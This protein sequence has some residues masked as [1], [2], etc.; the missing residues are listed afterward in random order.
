MRINYFNKEIFPNVFD[1][2]QYAL[3][4]ISGK[5][6]AAKYV[7]GSC[8]RFVNDLKRIEED[9][10]CPFYF[11][12][13][14]AERYLKLTQKFTHVVGHWDTENILY[15]PWQ[16]FCFA[17]IMGFYSHK[18]NERRFR[19]AHVEV[20]R[21]NGKSAMA[22]MA[23]LYFLALD[24]SKGNHISCVATRRDQARL[25]L[26]SARAMAKANEKFLKATG[27][28]VL[29]HKIIQE[30]TN[31]HVVAVSSDHSGLDGRADILAI[32]DELHQMQ[33]KTFE[34]IESGMAKRTDSL[35]LAITTSGYSLDGIGYS[36]SV[37]AK[38]V[39]TG[40]VIDESFFSIV[41][42]LDEG[43]DIFDEKNW[44]KA[45]PNLGVSVDLEK[46]RSVAFKAKESPRDIPNFKI[47]NLNLWL[48]ESKA[49]FDL[50][51]WDK[52]A[53]TSLK[54]E[55]FYGHKCFVG[56][57]LASKIDLSSF[58]YVFRK[59]GVYYIFDKTF[60]PED[61]VTHSRNA[62]YDNCI[63]QGHLIATPGEAIHYPKIK[64]DF[65]QTSKNVKIANALYDPWNATSFAQDCQNERIEMVEFRM[66][67]ANLSEP[68]KNLD[69]LIRQGKIRHNGSPL[70]RW[71]LGNVTAKEDAAGNVFP[72]KN[73][74][75]LKIDPIIALIMAVAAWM[76]EK[77][78][79]SNYATRGIR[80][81]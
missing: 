49:F 38:K 13:E 4:V 18:T 11:I 35:L 71:C 60:I 56:I 41:Y 23:C 46:L 67:T 53:D 30:S 61:T 24:K 26:D 44:F 16:K 47:K 62:L 14:K 76:N 77:E 15:Q 75:K 55:D 63:G 5:Q 10:K 31:S 43:D 8:L 7:I 70:L 6:I 58:V 20:A 33:A 74:D 39:A 72:K 66:N 59:N 37:Y 73:N 3:D 50:A 45:N 69:A 65:I 80:W 81:V 64:D 21:G 29:A 28:E 34:T 2:Y 27:V 48:S 25:V 68:T 17:N 40:E 32:C 54:F 22:S 12:P 36:Q 57:D 52:C 51:S 79:V 42:T 1:A 78:E 9:P 19:T